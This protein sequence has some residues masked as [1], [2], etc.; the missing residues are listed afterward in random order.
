M[1]LFHVLFCKEH[2]PGRLH[3]I[4]RVSNPHIPPEAA[5]DIW[6]SRRILISHTLNLTRERERILAVF[7]GS[8]NGILVQSDEQNEYDQANDY[9]ILI[10]STRVGKG[11]QRSREPVSCPLRSPDYC[12]ER[13]SGGRDHWKDELSDSIL[14]VITI[15]NVKG[16]EREFLMRLIHSMDGEFTAGMSRKT[17]ILIAKFSSQCNNAY[18]LFDD[19]DPLLARIRPIMHQSFY[20]LYLHPLPL[21]SD[22]DEDDAD[23]VCWKTTIPMQTTIQL[24]LSVQPVS[25]QDQHF[26]VYVESFIIKSLEPLSPEKRKIQMSRARE[27]VFRATARARLQLILDFNQEQWDRIKEGFDD[28]W[29]AEIPKA[30]V[31]AVSAA[32]LQGLHHSTVSAA[33]LYDSAKYSQPVMGHADVVNGV[34]FDGYAISTA[35]RQLPVNPKTTSIDASIPGTR[36]FRKAK[37]LV[38]LGKLSY[39]PNNTELAQYLNEVLRLEA[40]GQYSSRRRLVLKRKNRRATMNH[41]IL[42]SNRSLSLVS[43][44]IIWIELTQYYLILQSRM[45]WQDF[46]GPDSFELEVTTICA[47]RDSRW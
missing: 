16:D 42:P 28:N 44:Y 3:H 29:D 22:E 9:D 33:E 18:Q 1:S 27:E 35:G 10:T 17:V 12:K 20:P 14:K 34:L 47:G 23:V 37:A 15:T 6:E 26:A 46:I 2:I 38:G 11:L 41:P 8:A 4:Y 45:T 30:I 13:V 24:R 19:L 21:D 25:A 40:R 31:N 32:Q 43:V 7:I 39:E 5:Q 36:S